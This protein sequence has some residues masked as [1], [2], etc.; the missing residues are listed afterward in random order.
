MH[1]K[2]TF[3]RSVTH[4][5]GYSFGANIVSL[6][7]SVLTI[8]FLPKYMTIYDYGIF[9]LFIFYFSYIGIF[10]FGVL[11]GAIIRLSGKKYLE[12]D[13][14]GLKSQCIILFVILLIISVIISFI[15]FIKP[16]FQDQLYFYLFLIAMFAQHIVWYAVA[17]LQMSNRIEDASKLTFWERVSWGI[18]SIGIILIGFKDSISIIFMFVITR[19]LCMFYSLYMIKEVALA[20][21]HLNAYSWSQ[22]R[23]NF[24]LGFP[25]TLSDICSML[26][27]GIIRFGISKEWDISVFAK[28]S[29]VLSITLFFL[30]FINS[31][32]VVLLPAL[33]QLNSDKAKRLFLPLDRIV[34]YLLLWVLLFYYPLHIV[35][36][37]WLPKY[38][39]SL[40]YMGILFPVI[41]FEAKF[42][43]LVITYL[44]NIMKSM[45]IFY[46]NLV[47]MVISFCGCILFCYYMKNLFLSIALIV[48]VMGIRYILG[49]IVLNNYLRISEFMKKEVLPILIMTFLYETIIYKSNL[50]FGFI[51]NIIMLI[52]YGVINRR[53]F[54]GDYIFLK[55]IAKTNVE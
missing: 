40:L 16:I 47:S 7:I 22:F 53:N 41:L 44:K 32:S 37:F 5:L 4:K 35:V 50:L 48:I 34:S 30:S 26:I 33:R 27:V 13:F 31:A 14:C 17:I 21:V 52:V 23:T 25:I 46:L 2:N 18:L 9:Q 45:V 49:M 8:S 29:L 24:K 54:Y 43:F 3:G 39:D 11:G 28:T 36:S 19:F 1:M 42:S 55:D 20:N 6:L 15:N 12:L 51:L 10:H 38:A